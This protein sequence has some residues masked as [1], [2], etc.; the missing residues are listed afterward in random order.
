MIRRK[1]IEMGISAEKLASE[2][3]VSLSTVH[4]VLAG[5][6]INRNNLEHICRA[7][8]IQIAAFLQQEKDHNNG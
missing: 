2:A 1:M 4:R 3:G 7:L 5:R 6:R 8:N